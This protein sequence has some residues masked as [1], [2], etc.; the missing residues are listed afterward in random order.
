VALGLRGDLLTEKAL[1]SLYA[2]MYGS[3]PAPQNWTRQILAFSDGQL[4]VDNAADNTVTVWDFAGQPQRA[5][6]ILARIGT[7]P[8]SY[9][10]FADIG[11]AL[12]AILFA[13]LGAAIARGLSARWVL[14]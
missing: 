2:A 1:A 13:C 9:E 11:H 10:D 12:G 14:G 3:N 6:G 8:P 4:I 5:G 7:P